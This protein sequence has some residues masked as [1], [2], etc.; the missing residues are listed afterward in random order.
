VG[1]D[2][3]V[4]AWDTNTGKIVNA[5]ENLFRF[6]DYVELSRD[7]KSGVLVIETGPIVL[8]LETFRDGLE[9]PQGIRNVR[10]LGDDNRRVATASKGKELQIW[11]LKTGNAVKTFAM[12]DRD[13]DKSIAV[14]KC[15]PDGKLIYV[16][17]SH[18]APDLYHV[19]EADTGKV[20]FRYRMDKRDGA[21]IMSS[22]GN[23]VAF[24]NLEELSVIELPKMT[25]KK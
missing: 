1:V 25:A 24:R 21:P 7:G 5:W 3:S 20:V 9:L 23:L 13:S 14:A 4:R 22:P 12:V 18:V 17:G 19:M 2:F 6:P 8:N 15:S 11:D 10:F 16:G